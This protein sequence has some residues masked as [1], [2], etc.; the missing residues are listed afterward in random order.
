MTAYSQMMRIL[1]M[2]QRWLAWVSLCLC[3]FIVGT[4]DSF[5]QDETYSVITADNA[6]GLEQIGIM[7]GDQGQITVS[8]DNHWM[9]IAGLQGV[10]LVDLDAGDEGAQLLAGHTDT[11]T[12]VKFH[13][14]DS[15]ILAS[16]SS[17]GTIRLWNAETHEL[18]Q[19]IEAHPTPILG[20]N[21]DSSGTSIASASRAGIRIFNVETGEQTKEFTDIPQGLRQVEFLNNSPLLVGTTFNSSLAVWNLAEN[22]LVGEINTGF[23]GDVRAI[24]TTNDGQQ[25]AI[26]LFSGR[27][28]TRTIASG[29]QL[30]LDYHDGGVM[31][32]AYSSD[33]R[34]LASVGM[35]NKILIT[36][37]ANGDL[38]T[39][40]ELADFTYSVT[41]SNDNRLVY[42]ASNDGKVT[43][44]D[45]AHGQIVEDRTLAFPT[46]RQ[47]AYS[48]SGRY[49]AA[50]TDEDS[51][52]HV[53]NAQTNK[54]I[55]VLSG[56]EGRTFA[57]AYR[58][59]GRLI[60]TG[61]SGGDV[62]VWDTNTY[63]IVDTLS[64]GEDRIY[65][66]A[67][68]PSANI[69]AVGGDSFIR[70]WNLRDKK[71]ILA[72]DNGTTVWG[73][74]FSPDGS[75]IASSGGLWNGFEQKRIDVNI[76]EFASVAISPNSDILATT[77]KFIPI[78]PTR[79][80]PATQGYVGLNN[81]KI[82]FSPDGL[83]VAMAVS[84]NI[85]IIDVETQTVVTTLEGH[86]ADVRSLAF[87][88]DGTKLVSGG[89]DATIRQWA[90]VGDV[91]NPNVPISMDGLVLD[92]IPTESPAP[93]IT[94]TTITADTIEKVET[95]VLRQ[96][97]SNVIDI[98]VSPDGSSAVVA[99]LRGVFYIDLTDL[100]I[101]PIALLPTD[102]QI[103]P[104]GLAVD[105]SA[106][107]TQV[108]VSHGFARSQ[109]AVGGGITL[110]G[111]TNRKPKLISEFVITGDRGFSIALN[112]NKA[113]IAIGFDNSKAQVID[114]NSGTVVSVTQEAVF[115]RVTGISFSPDNAT[116]T[117]SDANGNKSF[118]RTLTGEFVGGFNSGIAIPMWWSP[119]QTYLYSAELTGFILRNG[120]NTEPI[121]ENRY[122]EDMRGEIKTTD[123]TN[124]QLVVASEN[125]IWFLDYETGEVTQ[126]ITGFESVIT[127]AEVTNDGQLL[128]A[129]TTD[130]KLRVWNIESGLQVSELELGFIDPQADITLSDDGRYFALGTK[131]DSIRLFSTETGDFIRNIETGQTDTMTFLPNSNLLAATQDSNTIGFWD[132]T[133]RLLRE[134]VTT[135]DTNIVDISPNG[136]YVVT[137]NGDKH[138]TLQNIR[139]G[140][141]IFDDVQLHL[142]GVNDADISITDN[143]MASAGDDGVVKLWDLEDGEQRALIWAHQNP[144]KRIAFAPQDS[145]LAVMG[146]EGVYVFD[147]RPFSTIRE[148][149]IF[150]LP[151]TSANGVYFS[152]DGSLLFAHVSDTLHV[153]SMQDGREL[154][155]YTIPDAVSI[156]TTDGD[157]IIATDEEGSIYRLAVDLP[158]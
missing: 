98:D 64:T 150:S 116:I 139:T 107:G 57:I 78:E 140:A 17:D 86:D 85:Q 32:V 103:F 34:M 65:S 75:L 10:W 58:R 89:Y 48:P 84:E 52:G 117:L 155:T 39:E 95:T 145:L 29:E 151:I 141:I 114:I 73:L 143:V 51:L 96:A 92:I 142:T 119:D 36:E 105:Y 14:T 154:A 28:I 49:I 101:P 1:N 99:S 22:K 9:A 11:V 79:I 106:D 2:R 130:N 31:D 72:F 128:I 62:L 118:F 102:A 157:Y 44:W 25:L 26:A 129:V 80:R 45:I 87:N 67:F 148:D 83:L 59:D 20:I 55:A 132:V 91:P 90:V 61:G 7:G 152:V 133:T 4:P 113:L 27:V 8:S 3:L 18:T 43:T 70:L 53:F 126:T 81:T 42:V 149:Y 63:D 104:S 50:V 147:Y 33:G 109:E 38:I 56:H 110:W 146:T 111:L 124:G 5:A 12:A 6:I 153:W 40:F 137:R 77:E 122:P 136:D 125:T 88:H 82:A 123:V 15:Q 30:I 100:T 23:N 69:I 19:T 134:I 71:E 127:T 158:D 97:I 93:V 131:E 135:D 115:G 121:R 74:S 13:P 16:A 46:V 21:Y 156:L 144:V 24:A 47:V 120:S 112:T 138:L 108:V 35:D 60:V 54:Q 76:G 94:E 41:F 68:S 66:L 37:S